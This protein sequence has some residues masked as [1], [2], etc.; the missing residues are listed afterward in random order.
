MSSWGEWFKEQTEVLKDGFNEFSTQLQDD[1]GEVASEVSAAAA[2]VKQNLTAEKVGET[3]TYAASYAISRGEDIADTANTVAANTAERLGQAQLGVA[4]DAVREGVSAASDQATSV[5]GQLF[6][7]L[8]EGVVGADEAAAGLLSTSKSGLQR[9]GQLAFAA[10]LVHPP[11]AAAA[12]LGDAA[13]A[14]PGPPGAARPGPQPSSSSPTS[15]MPPSGANGSS[16]R[17]GA[18]SHTGS[19]SLS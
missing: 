1:T 11:H 6:T 17:S 5:G 13:E 9:I 8:A 16:E 7:G 4:L 3:L 10:G 14:A 2:D 18:R 15:A 19:S 12:G